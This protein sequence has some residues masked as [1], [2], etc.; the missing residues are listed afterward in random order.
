MGHLQYCA[1]AR[2]NDGNDIA[3]YTCIVVPMDELH[4]NV[5]DFCKENVEKQ[6]ITCRVILEHIL[7]IKQYHNKYAVAIH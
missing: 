6:A 1:I 3:S 4:R 2:N 5:V 7:D